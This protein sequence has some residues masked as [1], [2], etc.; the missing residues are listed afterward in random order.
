MS[1]IQIQRRCDDCEKTRALLREV[2]GEIDQ[3]R[4]DY[5]SLYEKVRVNLS[6]L[7]KRAD[8]KCPDEAPEASDPLAQARTL[9]LQR[10]LNRS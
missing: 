3:I 7:A 2:K 6:K 10:K 8:G 5:H 9:L 4:L 1:L